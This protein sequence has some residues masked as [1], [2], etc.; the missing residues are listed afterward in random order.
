MREQADDKKD[1]AWKL[2]DAFLEGVYA[3]P[4]F[5]SRYDRCMAVFIVVV[6]FLCAEG[7]Q[8]QAFTKWLTNKIEESVFESGSPEEAAALK[9]VEEERRKR[10]CH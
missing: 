3:E 8:V 2:A 6:R 4:L 10:T 7:V 5:V 1:A 9:M